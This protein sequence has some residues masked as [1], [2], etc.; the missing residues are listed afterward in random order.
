MN[1][2][3]KKFIKDLEALGEEV[4]QAKKKQDNEYKRLGK[5]IKELV[6]DKNHCPGR[7]WELTFDIEDYVKIAKQLAKVMK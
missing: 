3:V 6:K 2:E 4:K 7:L 1:K 5:K